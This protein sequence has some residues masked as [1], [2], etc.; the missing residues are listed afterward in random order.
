[1]C[2]AEHREWYGLLLA[3]MKYKES[4]SHLKPLLPQKGRWL[5]LLT[6]SWTNI[7]I[8]GS[9]LPVLFSMSN[10]YETFNFKA[11]SFTFGINSKKT[12]VTINQ[13]RECLHV[14]YNRAVHVSHTWT[15]NSL[16]GTSLGA[17]PTEKP[18][19]KADT[20]GLFHCCEVEVCW[21]ETSVCSEAGLCKMWFQDGFLVETCCFHATGLLVTFKNE[22]HAR[23]DIH[24]FNHF[25]MIM[26]V[27][28]LKMFQ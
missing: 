18:W 19:T 4:F 15:L 16:K 28:S 10:C 22:L 3:L 11:F 9:H 14:H 21:R 12:G 6:V 20:S 17:L 13:L 7:L 27:F 8:L 1:M 24:M 25:K 26:A 23:Q 5:T 2:S